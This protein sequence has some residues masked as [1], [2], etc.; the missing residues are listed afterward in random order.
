MAEH[1][2]KTREQRVT[3]G[4]GCQL[5]KEVCRWG[6]KGWRRQQGCG[7]NSVCSAPQAQVFSCHI[8]PASQPIQLSDNSLQLLYINAVDYVIAPQMGG[9]D[10]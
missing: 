5:V 4:H 10:S 3:I 9:L 7:G 2:V 8:E 1:D 6:K